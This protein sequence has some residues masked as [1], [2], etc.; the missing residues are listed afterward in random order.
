MEGDRT[1]PHTRVPKQRPG[2][3]GAEERD[4]DPPGGG[5]R[6]F[7]GLGGSPAAGRALRGT[8]AIPFTRKPY[9][10]TN[11]FQPAF[12]LKGSA[13]NGGADQA[14]APPAA[15]TDAV[16]PAH[17]SAQRSGGPGPQGAQK[18]V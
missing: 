5:L 14:A 4:A 17:R 18:A 6:A 9:G 13:R 12:K 1:H 16:A 7:G 2:L 15:N 10:Y 8:E 3:G 11:L